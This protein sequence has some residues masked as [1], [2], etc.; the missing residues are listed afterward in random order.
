MLR[1][2]TFPIFLPSLAPPQEFPPVG[3]FKYVED[4]KR[5]LAPAVMV[6]LLFVQSGGLSVVKGLF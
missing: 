4:F 3:L 6:G 5:A 1:L 2:M